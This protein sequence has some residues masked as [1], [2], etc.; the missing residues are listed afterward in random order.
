MDKQEVGKHIPCNYYKRKFLILL[1]NREGMNYFSVN[2]KVKADL[3]TNP[4]KFGITPRTIHFIFQQIEEL[5]EFKF[6][7]FISYFQIYNEQI[8]DLLNPTKRS[9]RI[10][11]NKKEEFFVE[12]L[13]KFE[14][15]SPEQ[16]VYVSIYQI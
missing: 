14:C 1:K 5:K 3:N 6:K 10:R 8:F 7:I 11:W 12:N 16:V 4:S 9:L 2:G 15:T 13:F